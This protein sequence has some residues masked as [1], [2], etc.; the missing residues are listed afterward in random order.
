VAFH[1]T[2]NAIYH[3]HQ[4]QNDYQPDNGIAS[5]GLEFLK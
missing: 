4:Q 1:I 5:P 3:G 2:L